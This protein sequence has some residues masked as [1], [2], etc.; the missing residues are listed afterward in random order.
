MHKLDLVGEN[1]KN[2]R[3]LY[4]RHR[5]AWGDVELLETP[6]LS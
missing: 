5:M 4:S 6:N 1:V 3:L 2:P